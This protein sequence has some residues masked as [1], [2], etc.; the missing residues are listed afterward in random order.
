MVCTCRDVRCTDAAECMIVIG[1]Q[2][3]V[4]VAAAASNVTAPSFEHDQAH[5]LVT[6]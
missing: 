1:F 3:R 4:D 5:E 2:Q 6:S